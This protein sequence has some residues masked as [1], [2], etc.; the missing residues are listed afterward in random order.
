MYYH[1]LSA[2]SFATAT[3]RH[4]SRLR[5]LDEPMEDASS[6]SS[7][8]DIDSRTAAPSGFFLK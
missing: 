5:A 1:P 4:Y 8:H 7:L 3:L 2:V 6:Q